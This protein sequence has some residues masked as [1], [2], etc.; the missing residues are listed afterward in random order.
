M[1]WI[2]LAHDK[3]EWRNLVNRLSLWEGISSNKPISTLQGNII[4]NPK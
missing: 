4:M 2:N 1:D 3:G